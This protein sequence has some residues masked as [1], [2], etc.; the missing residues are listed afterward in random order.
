M[1][2]GLLSFLLSSHPHAVRLR[3]LFVFKMVPMMNPDGVVSGHF[4]ADAYGT[5]LNRAYGA[6]HPNRHPSVFAVRLV[7]KQM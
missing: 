4:R 7:L 1:F 6:P 3:D 2:H 5:N